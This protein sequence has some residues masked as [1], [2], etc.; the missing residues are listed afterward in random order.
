[1]LIK[2]YESDPSHTGALWLYM[3]SDILVYSHLYD[4]IVLVRENVPSA[5]Y[6]YHRE[7]IDLGLKIVVGMDCYKNIKRYGLAYDVFNVPL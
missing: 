4:E 2:S 6:D 3:D 5:T 1:M 7:N